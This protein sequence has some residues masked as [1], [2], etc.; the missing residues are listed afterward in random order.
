MI[1][2]GSPEW[3]AARC[4]KVTASRVEAVLAKGQKGEPSRT[5]ANY[6]AQLIAER[7]TGNVEEGFQSKEMQRGNEVEPEARSNYAFMFNAEIQ[8]AGFV[9]H[10]RIPMAGAS[11]DSFVGEDGLLELKCPN[12]ATHLDTLLGASID[13]GYVKQMMWQLA[14]TGRQWVDFCSY[15]NRL[16]AHLQLHVRRVYRDE[17]V[18]AEMEAAVVQFIGEIDA[19]IARLDA[20]AQAEAA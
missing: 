11:P 6:E 17:A 15:D 1:E 8:R 3:F 9:D 12:T 2:Q 20:I 19:K 18:I 4:G 13:G 5:R 10:P 16:P 7:L 14:C